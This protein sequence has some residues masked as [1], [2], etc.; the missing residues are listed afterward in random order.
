VK[1]G[2]GM[3]VFKS[4]DNGSNCRQLLID[5]WQFVL[6]TSEVVEIVVE[7]IKS[8]NSTGPNPARGSG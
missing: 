2:G 1:K 5:G 4:W 7:R 8:E 3:T 6:H